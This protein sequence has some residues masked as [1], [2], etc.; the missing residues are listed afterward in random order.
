MGKI[1]PVST[2][3][4][5]TAEITATGTV[6]KNDIVGAIFGQTEGLLG[7]ELEL[8]E[9]QKSGRIGRI[10]VNVETK[11]NETKGEIIVPSSMDKTET[12]IIAAALETIERIGPCVSKISVKSVDDVRMN[13][14]EQVLE[15]AK[16][17][18]KGMASTDTDTQEITDEVKQSVRA[19]SIM[20]YGPEKLSASN[21]IDAVKEILIVEGRA[22]VVNLIKYGF[23][24][25]I[26]LNGANNVPKTIK[27]LMKTKS[28]TLF[29]DGDRGGE[30]IVKAV[31]AAGGVE[32][33]AR[34]PDGKEVEELTGKE[35]HK[36][37]RSRM[38]MAEFEGK[39]NRNNHNRERDGRDRESRRPM[40]QNRNDHSDTQAFRGM[41]NELFGT[42]GAYLLDKNMTILGKVPVSELINTLNE[43]KDVN[44]IVLDGIIDKDL[45]SI[46]EEK[47]IRYLVSTDIRA[48]SK[49]V[50]LVQL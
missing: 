41:L 40:Q 6:D 14:R 47:G 29:I 27:N 44:A 2:K 49:S 1:Y 39:T 33:V 28:C 22:D 8:R 34:A 37:L 5:I 50:E 31:S 20:D 45:V 4:I 43:L 21:D 30:L 11:D 23:N 18:L 32:F 19:G 38:S 26:A 17:L 7:S 15:R 12:A 42:R 46:A 3:Y 16:H 24:G 35:I 13:K 48:K 36:A 10:E 9:L 25:V